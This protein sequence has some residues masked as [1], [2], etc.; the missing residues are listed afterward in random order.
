VFVAQ[1]TSCSLRFMS[2]YDAYMSFASWK[3][4]KSRGLAGFVRVSGVRAV[5]WPESQAPSVA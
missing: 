3:L 2:M 4:E 5:A 1:A